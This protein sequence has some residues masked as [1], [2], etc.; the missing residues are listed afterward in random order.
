MKTK[1]VRQ[2]QVFRISEFLKITSRTHSCIY[3]PIPVTT[4]IYGFACLF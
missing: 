3:I 4:E 2:K 1:T